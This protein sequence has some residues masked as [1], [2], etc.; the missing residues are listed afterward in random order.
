VLTPV[1]GS[2]FAAAAGQPV[3]AVA[4]APSGGVLAVAVRDGVQTFLV[5][6][7]TGSLTPA[8]GSLFEAG[9]SPSSVAVSPVGGLLATANGL[10]RADVSVFS[11][12]ASTGAVSQVPGSPF[13]AGAGPASV[14]FSPTGRLLAVANETAA[15]V[16]VFSVDTATGA[17][18]P[19]PGS[20][21]ADDT[22]PVSVA[23]SPAGGLL[24]TANFAAGSLSVYT[25]D[26]VTGA[27]AYTS[28]SPMLLSVQ[29]TAVA[30]SPNGQLLAT[31]N[32]N[33][34]VSEFSV[35]TATG[36]LTTIPGSPFATGS[37]PSAIAYSP[38]AR[39][40]ATGN[41]SD[42]VS[43]FSV[44][45]SSARLSPVVGSP[46]PTGSG[47]NPFSAAFSPNGKLLAT[48]DFGIGAVGMFAVNTHPSTAI[49]A[50]AG[51][52]FTGAVAHGVCAGSGANAAVD[53]GDGTAADVSFVTSTGD[54]DGAHT[55]STPGTYN[56]TVTIAGGCGVATFTATVAV[57]PSSKTPTSLAL[58]CSPGVVAVGRA[59]T[60]TATI[61]HAGGGSPTGRVTLAAS[62]PGRF[63]AGGRC[64]LAGGSCAVS[65]TPTRASAGTITITAGYGGDVG[66]APAGGAATIVSPPA[67][68]TGAV[69][70]LK[71][72]VRI[73]LPGGRRALAPRIGS[74]V[75]VPSGSQID[76][77]A[78]I[79]RVSTAADYL[80]GSDRHHRLQSG[81][82]SAGVFAIK[83]LTARQAQARARRARRRRLARPPT[84][85]QLIAPKGA[86]KRAGCRR[87]GSPGK[88]VVRSVTGVAKG[89]YR[90]MGAASTTS[91][92]QG[93]WTVQ[94]RCDGTLTTVRTGRATVSYRQRRRAHLA[95]LRAGQSLL[96][97]ARFLQAKRA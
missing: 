69:N 42:S 22:Q 61:G 18:S 45:P 33:A 81:V 95:R 3:D 97:R 92:T 55:Y 73:T 14:A 31:A 79:A 82:F 28:N 53:W 43:L 24:A 46:F 85:L 72:R 94:D 36:G 16:S 68:G 10:S 40:L 54:V 87:T 63:S 20:P 59:T 47:S 4:F 37:D 49:S 71:G 66:H 88:G 21:F 2:P 11:L 50:V 96:V 90:T 62:A 86:P 12:D 6:P 7:S 84:D 27:L 13:A 30:F 52:R 56:G 65:F 5:N 83:Q 75:A 26:S 19:V 48:A 77:R 89:V 60:C 51:T 32:S 35:S 23:F 8:G 93:A 67:A 78:G 25:V 76:V 39:L 34:S 41:H 91:V 38:D 57:P 70:V 80:R 74:T 15:N 44:D 64:T 29:P 58:A 1:T 9:A 17:L